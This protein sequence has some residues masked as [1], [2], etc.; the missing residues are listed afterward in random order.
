MTKCDHR[1]CGREDR[2]WLPSKDIKYGSI[3]KHPWCVECGTVKNISDD[4]PQ[5]IGFWM[6]KVSIVACEL[7]LTQCQKR[8]IAMEIKSNDYFNDCFGAFGSSQIREFIKIVDKYCDASLLDFD[9]LF[10]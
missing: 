3:E 8:L 2:V 5:T 6:N 9:T 4:R 7:K 10:Y 1:I